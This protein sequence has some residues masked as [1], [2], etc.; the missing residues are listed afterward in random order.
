MAGMWYW[1]GYV[2]LLYLWKDCKLH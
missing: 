1:Y 2:C